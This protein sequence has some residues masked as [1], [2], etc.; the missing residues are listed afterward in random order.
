M[1][2][3]LI[4]KPSALGDVIQATC[5]LPVIKQHYPDAK[6][7][8]F[9]FERNQDIVVDHPLID[10]VFIAHKNLFHLIKQLRR[11]DFDA[12]IDLQGLLRSALIAFFS[13]CNRRIGFANGREMSPLFYTEKYDIPIESVH[14][15][16]RYLLLL[17]KLGMPKPK[18]VQFPLPIKDEHRN[19]IKQMFKREKIITIGPTARWPSK[20]WPESS[21]AALANKLIEKTKAKIVLVG[22][23]N[24]TAIINNV[25]KAMQHDGIDLCGQLSLME[26][27]ALLERSSLFVGNDSALMHMASATKTPT[28]AIF[29]PT[30]P[31]RTGPYNPLAKVVKAE[32]SCQPC[33]RKHCKQHLECMQ[34][35][36]PDVVLDACLLCWN[37]PGLL[38]ILD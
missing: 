16:D 14:A 24:E 37:H 7:S 6:I 18:E 8:W 17:E 25:I 29:G 30:D 22:A 36:Q 33:F 23:P 20:C 4:V 11:V 28:V 34:K 19:R 3:I 27:A 2:N 35:L 1:K 26:I 13:G 5:I 31:K 15:V 32:I 10:S 21:F 9:V 38:A 12:V